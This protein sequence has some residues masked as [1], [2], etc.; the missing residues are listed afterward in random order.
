MK[1]KLKWVICSTCMGNGKIGHPALSNGFTWS[2]WNQFHMEEQA[3]YMDGEYDV[4]CTACK[5]LGRIRVPDVAAMSY[6]EKRELVLQRR[7]MREN[8]RIDA[9]MDA[10]VAAERAFGC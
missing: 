9:E 2:E 10:D 1:D 8:A 7:E 6:E 5:G 3:A 4:V